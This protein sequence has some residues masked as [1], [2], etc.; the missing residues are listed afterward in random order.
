ML[1]CLHVSALA[2]LAL[3]VHVSTSFDRSLAASPIKVLFDRLLCVS[4][5]SGTPFIGPLFSCLP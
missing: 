3:S 5:L 2:R 4:V 1:A